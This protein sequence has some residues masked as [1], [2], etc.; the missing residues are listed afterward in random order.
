MEKKKRFSMALPLTAAFTWFG[1]HCGS[2]F[3]SGTQMKVYATKFGKMGLLAPIVAWICC[4]AFIY[5][6][7]EYAR[8][9]QA[10][11]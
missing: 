5:I 7:V 2:G 4:A 11:T 3:A 9:V 8:L 1:Y 6:I 10:K